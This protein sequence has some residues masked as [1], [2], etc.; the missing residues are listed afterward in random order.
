MKNTAHVFGTSLLLL[1]AAAATPAQEKS[2][3][4]ALARSADVTTS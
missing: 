4:D 2:Q 1:A 3:A